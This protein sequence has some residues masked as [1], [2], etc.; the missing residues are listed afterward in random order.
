MFGLAIL[1]RDGA[2]MMA[3][4]VATALAVVAGVAIVVTAQ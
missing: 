2:L 4:W 1:V 3:A